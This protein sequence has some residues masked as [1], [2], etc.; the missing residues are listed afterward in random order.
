M[1]GEILDVGCGSGDLT[2]EIKKF[3][4]DLEITGCDKERK[5]LDYYRRHSDGGVKMTHCDAHKLL[6]GDASFNAVLMLDVLEHLDAPEDALREAHR[7]LRKGGVF[8]LAVPCERS[9]AT[10]DGWLHRFFKL[11][12]KREPVGHIQLFTFEGVRRMLE[13]QG[14]EVAN[15]HFS[16][17]F[18]DQS[19]SLPYYLFIRIFR[20]G[21]HLN[22]RQK[23]EG[24]PP[25]ALLLKVGAWLANFESR[26]LQKVRGR[27]LHITSRK[28]R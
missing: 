14:F 27:T 1:E 21:G 18:L 2:S 26:I 6:F 20:R 16:Q 5:R 15:F 22:L 28:K 23:G 13:D 9:L 11:N 3:T 24:F 4:P 19:F 12:L 17:H 7:V 10:W 8:H 25:L